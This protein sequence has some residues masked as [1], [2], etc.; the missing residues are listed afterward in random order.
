MI[1]N[2]LI[3][4]KKHYNRSVIEKRALLKEKIK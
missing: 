1:F 2:V 3:G 4:D